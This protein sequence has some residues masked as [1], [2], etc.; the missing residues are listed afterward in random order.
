MFRLCILILCLLGTIHTG[1]ARS[2]FTGYS[3]APGRQ[4]CAISCHGNSNGTATLSGFPDEYT[5]GLTYT[6][7]LSRSSGNSIR[8]FN[9]S[10]RLGTGTANAGQLTAGTGTATY[11]TTGETNGIHLSSN[12][13]NSATFNWTAPAAG[14]GQVRLYIGAYQGSGTNGQTSDLNLIA[15]EAVSTPPEVVLLETLLIGD[16]DN[17]GIAEP[18][19]TLQLQVTLGNSGAGEATGVSAI[20][21]TNDDWLSIPVDASQWSDLPADGSGVGDPVFE[22]VLSD[23]APAVAQADLLLDIT[24]DQADFQVV[25]PLSVGQRVPYWTDDVEGDPLWTHA[26]S[27]DWFDEWHIDTDDATPAGNAWK[28]GSIGAGEYTPHADGRLISPPILLQDWSLLEFTHRMDAETSSASP[29]SAYDGGIVELSVDDG[30]TWQQLVP[31]G[32]HDKW[33][34][35]LTG[36]GA[37]TTHPFQGGTPCYSGSFGWQ[38]AA[39]DLA[40]WAGQAV[41]IALR[42]GSDDGVQLAGWLVDNITVS[43]VAGEVAVHEPREH[44]SNVLMLEAYPNP[45]NPSTMIRFQ[46]AS[47][48]AVRLQL[49]DIAGRRALPVQAGSFPAGSSEV[50]L[51]ASV[52]PSGPYVLELSS[53]AER[54]TRKLLLIH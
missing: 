43:G 45:F 25:I 52:L 12:S 1:N 40:P 19:E 33:F 42:F 18:G 24:T 29:D 6:L 21:S 20:L 47:A 15:E 8:N 32:G 23:L 5:P 35:R 44:P 28:F 36:G 49:Y 10:V 39:F 38:A 17:D 9:G 11:S 34:R 22:L 54:C 3:G 30:D 27:P 16:S 48:G 53:G 51:D 13:Q 46:L 41:R 50:Q 26:A 14:S 37:P 4:T 2:N 7:T 31:L